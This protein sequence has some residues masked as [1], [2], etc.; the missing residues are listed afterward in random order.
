[1]A[2]KKLP[3]P[4]RKPIEE[5]RY[6]RKVLNRVYLEPD[7][8][9]LKSILSADD[10]GLVRPVRELEPD[11][12]KRLKKLSK[13]IRRNRGVVQKGKLA[14]LVIIVASAVVFDVAFKNML[15]TR[16]GDQLLQGVF[17]ARADL[18]GVDFRPLRGTIAFR[19]LTVADKNHPMT[20]LFELGPTQLDVDTLK[21]LG[22]HLVISRMEARGIRWGTPR[23]SSGAISGA[24]PGTAAGG[25]SP[26]LPPVTSVLDS[27]NL[28]VPGSFDAKAFVSEHAADL[29]TVARIDGL[30]AEGDRLAQTF[31]DR[32]PALA[33]DA[34]NATATAQQIS[35][36]DVNRI[37]TLDAALAAYQQVQDAAAAISKARDEIQR[38]YNEASSGVDA[39]SSQAAEI[40][41]LVSADSR[42][43]A[44]LV[45]DISTGGREIVTQLVQAYVR[46]AIGDWYQRLEQG[47]GVV[48]RLSDRNAKTGPSRTRRLPGR[49]VPFPSASVPRFWLKEA[50]FDAAD[51]S[52]TLAFSGQLRALSSDPDLIRQPATFDFKGS[53]GGSLLSLHG[54]VDARKGAADRVYLSAASEGMPLDLRSGLDQLDISSVTG[55][56][57]LSTD[58][59]LKAAGGAE[60][61]IELGASSISVTGGYTHDSF[62]GI[63][64][65]V[66]QQGTPLDAAFTFRVA[67]DGSITFPA[68][69]SNLDAVLN[70]VLRARAEE[71]T[72]A[73]Q[74][75]VRSQ[76][77]ALIASRQTDIDS[78]K[79]QVQSVRSAVQT[80]L[81]SVNAARDRAAAVQKQLDARIAS[82][83]AQAQNKA[84]QQLQNQLDSLQ[85]GL[86]LPGLGQ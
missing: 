76:L 21:L 79:V 80:Q 36:I 47:Y 29:K 81:D 61:R 44:T 3:K 19:S 65:D 46:S 49:D 27:L 13:E 4:F 77:D 73:L 16:A 9:Y 59:S 2:G 38:S 22:G 11:E 71:I 5:G 15:V 45:P 37:N 20:N 54:S 30:T 28:P 33:A 34:Q 52:S 48:T 69:S 53:S 14:I 35:T 63:I 31:K 85:K 25:G 70:S 43:L 40:P 39:F 75:R 1:M 84:Q 74:S 57:K 50:S 58:I 68:G 7:R 42:Y 51:A 12:L 17:Q 24:A 67:P 8:E 64:A 62:G 56:L 23:K 32:V 18:G 41:A 86:K 10:A 6:L 26:A 72:G 66:L 83:K 82:I 55:T 60:G 78:A